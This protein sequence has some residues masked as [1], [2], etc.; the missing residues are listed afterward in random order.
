MKKSYYDILKIDKNSSADEI[1]SAFKKQAM[2][3][4]PDRNKGSDAETKFK[5]INQAYG[6]LGDANKKK[7]YDQ[8]E[9]AE[10]DNGGCQDYGYQEDMMS[11]FCTI[12]NGFKAKF[13]S[14]MNVFLLLLIYEYKS[15][16]LKFFGFF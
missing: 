2:E 10:Q 11:D 15:Y 5:E 3:Y 13:Q 4:H 8:W 6:V 9:T 12:H 1:K 16:I 7:I 14:L